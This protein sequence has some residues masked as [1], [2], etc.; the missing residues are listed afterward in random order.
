MCTVVVGGGDCTMIPLFHYIQNAMIYMST[1]NKSRH[2]KDN[3]RGLIT[4]EEKTLR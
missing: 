4:A 1:C 2:I 3:P